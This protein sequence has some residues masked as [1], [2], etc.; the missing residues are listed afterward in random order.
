MCECVDVSVCVNGG[1]FVFVW[2]FV[3]VNGG[4]CV[5]LCGRVCMCVGFVM[6][7]CFGNMYTVP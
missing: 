5:C 1:V 2:A 7:G 3:C 4:V 6:Y